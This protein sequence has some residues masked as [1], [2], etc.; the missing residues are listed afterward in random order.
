MFYK[1]F[2]LMADLRILGETEYKFTKVM[3][4]EPVISNKISSQYT[5]VQEFLA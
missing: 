1:I 5:L 4:N 3:F 2:S